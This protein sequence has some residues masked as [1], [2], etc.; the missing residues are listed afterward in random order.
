MTCF[1]LSEQLSP[2]CISGDAL[3]IILCDEEK[4]MTLLNVGVP[5]GFSGPSV[6]VLVLFRRVV[7]PS[8]LLFIIQLSC[9]THVKLNINRIEDS[10]L[11]RALRS[12]LGSCNTLHE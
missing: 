6:Q 4:E 1:V 5:D 11:G 10:P 12:A 3:P 8:S 2:P 7:F 9:K